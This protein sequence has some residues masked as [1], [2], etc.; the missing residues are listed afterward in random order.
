MKPILHSIVIAFTLITAAFPADAQKR[1]FTGEINGVVCASCK[2]HIKAM[3]SKNIP[4]LVSVDVQ[5]GATAESPR[6]LIIVAQS[7][8]LTRE[9]VVAALGSLA[10]NYEVLS[11]KPQP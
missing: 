9:R 7:E 1:V 10:K 11:L 8:S 4:G 2:E 6:K 5:P 3:L